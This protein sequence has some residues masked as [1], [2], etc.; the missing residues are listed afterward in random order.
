MG[1]R[2]GIIYGIAFLSAVAIIAAGIFFTHQ[3]N[4]QLDERFEEI[5]QELKADKAEGKLPPELSNFD[6]D[7]LRLEDMG[8][9]LPESFKFRV[10]LS[11]WMS[12]F[13][14]VL[15]PLVLALCLGVAF[16]ANSVLRAIAQRPDS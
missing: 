9:P 7:S 6:I 13:W 16:F 11:R 3:T 5:K 10:D 14:Y 1:K 2:R 15:I 12:D 8:M 4:Q